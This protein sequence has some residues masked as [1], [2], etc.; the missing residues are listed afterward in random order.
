MNRAKAPDKLP[1]GEPDLTPAK[2]RVFFALTI[3]M[4]IVFLVMLELGLRWFGYGEDVSLFKR[5]EI[6]HQMYYQ[7]NPQVKFRYFGTMR[8]TPSTLSLIHI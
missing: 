3:S 4:P 1:K 7:M 8:F 2:Q 6:R 5:V